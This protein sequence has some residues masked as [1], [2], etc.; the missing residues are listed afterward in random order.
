MTPDLRCRTLDV[1]MSTING[2]LGLGLS[3]SSAAQLLRRM[4]LGVEVS[5]DGATL[6]VSVPPTR[7]DVLHACDVVEDVAIAHG[8]NNI[9]KRVRVRE[10]EQGWC[11][12]R[13]GGQRHM[14]L[15]LNSVC[16]GPGAFSSCL[17][18]HQCPPA[19][20]QIPSAYTQGRELPLNQ[21]SEL[22]R[23]ECAMAGY[24]EVLTW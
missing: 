7:S 18:A 24:T 6:R 19:P 21:F 9:P 13:R 22:L 15:L 10:H 20:L 16:G 8:Y 23:A 14:S 17:G 2:T 5:G 11:V 1:P 4:Q 3:G 12:R